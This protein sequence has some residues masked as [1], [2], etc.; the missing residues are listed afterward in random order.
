MSVPP[1]SIATLKEGIAVSAE[2]WAIP[3][4]K[5]LLDPPAVDLTIRY[6]VEDLADMPEDQYSVF[7]SEFPQRFGADFDVAC[8][9]WFGEIRKTIRSA[10]HEIRFV[11]RSFEPTSVKEEQM[12]K[13]VADANAVL[14]K[15][16]P[17]FARRVSRLAQTAYSGALTAS[18]RAMKRRPVKA[19]A[20]IATECTIAHELTPAVMIRMSVV[21][22]TMQRSASTSAMVR[23]LPRLRP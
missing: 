7:S 20:K 14:D 9:A 17:A 3:M 8:R 11:G 22:G 6:G 12:L 5:K 10:E 15:K 16:C 19:H 18:Y 13:V 2:S 1:I 23:T 21:P 4:E